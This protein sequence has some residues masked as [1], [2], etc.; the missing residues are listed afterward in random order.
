MLRATW[1]LSSD[2]ARRWCSSC[3]DSERVCSYVTRLP[4]GVT[5]ENKEDAL[6][7]EELQFLEPFVEKLGIFDSNDVR[8][9][10]SLSLG[11]QQVRAQR[12][13]QRA[14]RQP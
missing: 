2:P 9:P 1:G 12:Q 7:L 8:V 11:A 5:L 10:L 13:Y 6:I 4:E 14:V 3:K